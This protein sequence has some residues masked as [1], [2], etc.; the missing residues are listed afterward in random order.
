MLVIIGCLVPL[1]FPLKFISQFLAMILNNLTGLTELLTRKAS[2][3]PLATIENIGMTNVECLLFTAAIFLFTYFL[4]KKKSFQY[5]LSACSS[6]DFPACRNN[7]GNI[8]K[9]HQ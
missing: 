1:L 4:L 3:L 6:S 7:K 2:S 9:K 5:N 8:N